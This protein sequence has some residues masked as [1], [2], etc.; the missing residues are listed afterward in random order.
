MAK[1]TTASRPLKDESEAEKRRREAAQSY[2]AS[3]DAFNKAKSEGVDMTDLNISGM[4]DEQIRAEGNKRL[5]GLKTN[6]QQSISA[7]RGAGFDNAKAAQD[8]LNRGQA[9]I[10]GD[11]LVGSAAGISASEWAKRDNSAATGNFALMPEKDMVE[12][13]PGVKM[14]EATAQKYAS[15]MRDRSKAAADAQPNYAKAQAY[16]DKMWADKR[17]RENPNGVAFKAGQEKWKATLQAREDEKNIREMAQMEQRAASRA[18]ADANAARFTARNAR[19]PVAASE[20]AN[21]M[22]YAAETRL[23]PS[24]NTQV[25]NDRFYENAKKDFIEKRANPSKESS[26]APN[27]APASSFG[28]GIPSAAPSFSLDSS[29]PISMNLS[30]ESGTARA[31]TPEEERQ[32]KARQR[33]NP[34]GFANV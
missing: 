13:A 17:D 27:T 6:F 18:Y 25:R 1:Q 30:P 21:R 23:G 2:L 14:G 24:N 31:L 16:I 20:E 7:A 29:A 3:R 22:F 26:P 8:Y 10:V 9:R 15:N 28:M 4:S 12:M 5:E 19:D 33:S 11:T 32:A 34:Y